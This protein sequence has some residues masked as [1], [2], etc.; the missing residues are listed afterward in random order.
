MV[1]APWSN[2]LDTST[3]TLP[4]FPLN[5]FRGIQ[6]YNRSIGKNTCRFWE[7]VIGFGCG[8]VPDPF[9]SLQAGIVGYNLKLAK[10]H[11]TLSFKIGS[12]GFDSHK[13]ECLNIPRCSLTS[14]VV[15]L[16]P[17]PLKTTKHCCDERIAG[18]S[19][20]HPLSN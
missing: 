3:T 10:H 17:C 7:A 18:P 4:S 5:R 20:L 19:C 16:R 15:L 8:V 14:H 6:G 2:P 13:N 11:V 9:L 12:S 1:F